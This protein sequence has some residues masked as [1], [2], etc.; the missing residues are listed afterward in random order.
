MFRR[1]PRVR[2]LRPASTGAA[3]ELALR[4]PVVNALG[5]ARLRDLSG[6]L[7]IG[8]EFSFFGP[9]AEPEGVLWNGVN[10]SAM[11]ASPRA[12]AAFGAH[13]AERG[14]RASSIV[15]ERAAVE[16][17]WDVL[18]PIWDSQVREYRWSQPLLLAQPE[19]TTG[20]DG[21][22]VSSRGPSTPSRCVG[23]RAAHPDE[24]DAVP[25]RGLST[26]SRCGGLR[27]AHPDEVDA[28]PSRGLSTPSRCGGLRAAHPDEV[29]AVFPAAVA[30]FREEV[31]LDPTLGDHGRAY[32]ARVV[33]LLRGGR[34]YVVTDT[35]GAVVFKADVGAL[36]GP[37]A[38]IHGVWTR[39][40][41]R[42]RGIGRRAMSDLVTQVRRDHA[43]QVSLYV[44]DF[45]A[46]ARRAYAAAGFRQVGELST[47][48][49]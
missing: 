15:G 16:T 10:I 24:V 49:F 3:L 11:Q 17:L 36:F 5:G 18:G 35:D 40:D 34:T 37:V 7:S 8:R 2:P 20:A 26:P 33:E 21:A 25:S 48:L 46:P 47:I 9:D 4:D 12:L 27:A 42:G 45:N 32:R 38:Q 39:P 22:A 1:A 29:D 19:A 30:M 23:L 43:P 14:R 31:G 41:M 6:A 13:L 44:N 28:V